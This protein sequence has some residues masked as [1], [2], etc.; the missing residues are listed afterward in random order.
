ML[1]FLYKFKISLF[2]KAKSRPAKKGC[3][4][5]EEKMGYANLDKNRV[6]LKTGVTLVEVIIASLLL[7]VCIVPIL[8]ALSTISVSRGRTTKIIQN[9]NQYNNLFQELELKEAVKKA[10][11]K[12]NDKKYLSKT[13]ISYQIDLVE[14]KNQATVNFMDSNAG[15]KKNTIKTKVYLYEEE[16]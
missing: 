1:E 10:D 4:A 13:D 3:E 15:I 7:A 14:G 11:L 5:T 6:T 12:I 16:K 9:N 2:S 8:S